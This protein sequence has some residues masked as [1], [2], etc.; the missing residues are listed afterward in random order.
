MGIIHKDISMR[1]IL[2]T[3]N[4]RWIITD[5]GHDQKIMVN[6]LPCLN[7]PETSAIKTDKRIDLHGTSFTVDI[8]SFGI[9][10][11]EIMNLRNASTTIGISNCDAF[12]QGK[13][14]IPMEKVKS[15]YPNMVRLDD[16]CL[17]I[18]PMKRASIRDILEML[19]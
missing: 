19:M 3:D 13:V 17:V 10:A 7:A 8:W 16:T 11:W 18:D 6:S 4:M 15:I 9:M 5:F 12:R 2:V 14:S 1:N